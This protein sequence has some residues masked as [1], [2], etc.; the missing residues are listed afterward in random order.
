MT[1]P[2]SVLRGVCESINKRPSSCCKE[3]MK[4]Y[5]VIWHKNLPE[6]LHVWYNLMKLV[7]T[8]YKWRR[9]SW[10]TLRGQN[11]FRQSSY[12]GKFDMLDLYILLNL[13]EKKT[14]RRSTRSTRSRRSLTKYK[15]IHSGWSCI[16]SI[17]CSQWYTLSLVTAKMTKAIQTYPR[18][19]E[20]LFK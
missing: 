14:Y 16:F 18:S 7:I 15:N 10:A 11:L 4:S 2:T 19:L 5:L 6:W 13:Y 12:S 3:N 8:T 9:D 20:S 1:S 17:T